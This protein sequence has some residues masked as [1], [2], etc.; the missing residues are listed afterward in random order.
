MSLLIA[1]VLMF[2]GCSALKK[3]EKKT[4][5]SV[6]NTVYDRGDRQLS[7]ETGSTQESRAAYEP[8]STAGIGES[9][10]SG[11][12]RIRLDDV[13]AASSIQTGK[14]H[15]LY[16]SEGNMYLF[17]ELTLEDLN[18]DY[19]EFWCN[20]SLLPSIDGRMVNLVRYSHSYPDKINKLMNFINHDLIT[21]FPD[22]SQK[23]FIA[24][25]VPRDFKELEIACCDHNKI[26]GRFVFRPDVD[27]A[28][29]G[30]TES[31]PDGSGEQSTVINENASSESYDFTLFS[32][33]RV[34][35]EDYPSLEEADNKLYYAVSLTARNKTDSI[36]GFSMRDM[37]LEAGDKKIEPV[38]ASMYIDS[39]L[40]DK[41]VYDTVV[42]ELD[43]DTVNGR[44]IFNNNP[45]A[46]SD[47]L[48]NIDF[49]PHGDST[50]DAP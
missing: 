29:S 19:T 8:L 31:S 14:D 24:F 18:I 43:K 20:S 37:L 10:E 12:V 28:S 11:S 27:R 17:A 50:A 47:P 38:I 34:T 1:A 41:F 44:L 36:L 6:D 7:G 4:E 9:I 3:R 22:K 26:S 21:V 2:S 15:F 5:H 32:C 48:F 23:G 42:F 35:H 45:D 30:N 13:Y 25:H 16:P 49:K 39:V 33:K 40:P 46:S